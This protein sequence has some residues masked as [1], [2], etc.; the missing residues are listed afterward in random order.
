[1]RRWLLIATNPETEL[2]DETVVSIA[3]FRSR[4]EYEEGEVGPGRPLSEDLVEAIVALAA[5]IEATDAI[6]VVILPLDDARRLRFDL[7]QTA[8]LALSRS[9]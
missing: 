2:Y 6:E 3:T 8:R 4:G 7:E 5:R 1:V 9:L